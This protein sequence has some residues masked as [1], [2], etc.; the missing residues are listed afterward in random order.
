LFLKQGT[1]VSTKGRDPDQEIVYTARDDGDEP[2]YPMVVLVNEGTASASEIVAGALQDHHR[3]VVAGERTFGKGSVQTIL[4]LSD[5]S[6]L[7]IT[8]ALYYTPS[9][10]SIQARGIVP[11]IAI[12]R[13]VAQAA[14]ERKGPHVQPREENLKGHFGTPNENGRPTPDREP[15]KAEPPPAEQEDLQLQRAVELV[16]S[17]KIFR[18]LEKVPSAEGSAETRNGT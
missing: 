6:G 16:K 14:P 2:T 13:Q 1:V 15:G 8:T 12:S 7:R 10:R 5:G 9:D 11:D 17:W 3:A 18:R 4:P